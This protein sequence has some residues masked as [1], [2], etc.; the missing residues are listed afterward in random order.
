MS[1]AGGSGRVSVNRKETRL[2]IQ[3]ED[4]AAADVAVDGMPSV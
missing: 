4:K 3:A 1:P 2:Q